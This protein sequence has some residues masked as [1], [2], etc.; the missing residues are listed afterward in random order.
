MR[1]NTIAPYSSECILLTIGF[2]IE[3]TVLIFIIIKSSSGILIIIIGC[4]IICNIM[5]YH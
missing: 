4:F 3:P 2:E 5:L 1:D